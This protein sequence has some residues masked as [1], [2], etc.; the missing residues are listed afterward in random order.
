MPKLLGGCEREHRKRRYRDLLRLE[1]GILQI[2][3]QILHK[4]EAKV[5]KDKVTELRDRWKL[6]VFT[7]RVRP[8]NRNELTPGPWGIDC[9][10]HPN[11]LRDTFAGKLFRRT[12]CRFK[13]LEHANLSKPS[14]C[15]DVS[16]WRHLG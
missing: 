14:N 3:N 16:I 6:Y 11:L 9:K 15:G 7:H 12:S 8:L 5:K 13:I 10:A 2:Q 4:N 1:L